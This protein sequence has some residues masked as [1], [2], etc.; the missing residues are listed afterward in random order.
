VLFKQYAALFEVGG[1]KTLAFSIDP[2][3]ADCIDGL[4]LTELALLKP[5]KRQ[6]Y[7]DK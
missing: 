1:F 2:D 5:A 7:L 3:F 6:R 4:C